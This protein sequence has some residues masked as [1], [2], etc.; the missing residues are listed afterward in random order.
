M[1]SSKFLVN[2]DSNSSAIYIYLVYGSIAQYAYSLW[3]Y[4]YA[5]SLPFLFRI[6]RSE[7]KMKQIWLIPEISEWSVLVL[8][9]ISE[10]YLFIF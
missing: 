1:S 2:Q 5:Y 10:N 8:I 9:D 4:H 7:M 3:W 6:K